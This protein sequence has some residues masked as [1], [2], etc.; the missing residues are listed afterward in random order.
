MNTDYRSR[1]DNLSHF[2][3][4]GCFRCHGSGQVNEAGESL[5]IAC[6]TCHVIVAQGP[7]DDLSAIESSVGGLEFQHPAPIGEIWQTVSCTQCHTRSS[8][9]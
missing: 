4:E 9:Y 8:G 1:V 5:P 7:T 2:V 3:N 6:D